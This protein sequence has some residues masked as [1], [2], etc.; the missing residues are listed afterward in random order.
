MSNGPFRSG[1]IQRQL[2]SLSRDEQRLERMFRNL[3]INRSNSYYG[4]FYKPGEVDKI[5]VMIINDVR[6]DWE[7]QTTVG[8]L[9]GRD[10]EKAEQNF[11]ANEEDGY[12]GWLDEADRYSKLRSDSNPSKLPTD[13]DFKDIEDFANNTNPEDIPSEGN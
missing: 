5:C 6:N 12:D 9:S 11:G 2:H 3:G 8:N 4:A 1:R 13:Q 10:L 7:D